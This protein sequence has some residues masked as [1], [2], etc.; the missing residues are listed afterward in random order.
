MTI[1][2]QKEVDSLGPRSKIYKQQVEQSNGLQVV[3]RPTGGKSFVGVTTHNGKRPQTTIGTTEIWSLK[4]AREE[5]SKILKWSKVTGHDPREYK[6]IG[7]K[8]K[9]KKAND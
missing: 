1:K 3:V 7:L 4:D 6:K 8:P 2:Y 5:W 9:V